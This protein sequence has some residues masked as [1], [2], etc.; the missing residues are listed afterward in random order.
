MIYKIKEYDVNKIQK[1]GF[2][3]TMEGCYQYKKSG[4]LYGNHPTI[5]IYYLFDPD[6][7]VLG[8][9][10]LDENYNLCSAYYN[11]EFGKN[12]Y[13]TLIRTEIKNEINNMMKNGVFIVK[14]KGRQN[15]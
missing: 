1:Y 14:S 3:R 2:K 15:I 8:V 10:V 11:S 12:S 13:I 4:L 9:N 7:K 6:E 5:Y